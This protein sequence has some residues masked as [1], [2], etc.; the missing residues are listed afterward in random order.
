MAK[1]SKHPVRAGSS[2]RGKSTDVK[3]PGWPHGSADPQWRRL[4]SGA[5]LG[6]LA[7][8]L[9]GALPMPG[10]W[11]VRALACGL[12]VGLSVRS[13]REILPAAGLSAV[14]G[15]LAMA[16]FALSPGARKLVAPQ[17]PDMLAVVVVCAVVAV[18]VGWACSRGRLRAVVLVA[19]V[20]IVGLQLYQT[21]M[22]PGTPRDLTVATRARVSTEPQ[23][24]V[25]RFDG[26]L[27][28]K[29][30][31]LV[32]QGV[33]YYQ[34]F[35][36]AFDQ[37]AR[38]QG[39]PPGLLNIRQRWL[40]EF[41]NILPGPPGLR[42]LW[43]FNVLAVATML[44]GYGVAR[45]F[46]EPAAAIIAPIAIGGYLLMPALTLWFP[47]SEYW[48]GM[49]AVFFLYAMVTER[50]T[51]GAVLVVVAFAFRELMLFLVPVYVVWWLVSSRRREA[52]GGLAVAILGPVVLL[53][54]HALWSPVG[55]QSAEGVS[56]WFQGGAQRLI[57]ALQ[58][59]GDLVGASDRIYLIVPLLA[60]A[61]AFATRAVWTKALLCAAVAVPVIA[62]TVFSGGVWGYY[63]GAIAMPMLLALV[64]LV[65]GVVVPSSRALL[66]GPA[67]PRTGRR[68]FQILPRKDRSASAAF[69]AAAAAEWETGADIVVASRLATVA[70]AEGSPAPRLA[71]WVG[72]RVLSSLCRCVCPVPGLR[73]MAAPFALVDTEVLKSAPA[74]VRSG[75]TSEGPSSAAFLVWALEHARVR[76]VALAS[77]V[78]SSPLPW[79]LLGA[80]LAARVRAVF[81]PG[82]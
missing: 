10:A 52:V 41:W 28:I 33:P 25:Y 24:E 16:V 40:F 73:D 79:G 51:W 8:L 21:G 56:R 7:L 2:A 26:D 18:V 36:R 27:F 69:E 80:L 29:I 5:A 19:L 60:L 49:V 64:P 30:D 22:V 65:A 42:V 59:S 35:L 62:L 48:A 32:A 82:D 63:W 43:G 58:F 34:A 23:A 78:A 11:A 46:V 4:L 77:S 55:G 39:Q 50:W 14:A 72:I 17:V 6:A 15:V 81:R 20:V 31:Y 75:L 70:R 37:D 71:G 47:L 38:L 54:L 68:A 44:A 3:H 57:D 67:A 76:E 53:G 9:A 61:G 66:D 74:D 45:R 1:Q 13:I 12:V